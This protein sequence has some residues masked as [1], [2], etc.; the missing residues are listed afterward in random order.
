[1]FGGEGK[2]FFR[3]EPSRK[4]AGPDRLRN[5]FGQEQDERSWK[6]AGRANTLAE[7]FA[8]GFMK[9]DGGPS[10]ARTPNLVIKS[11][12]LYR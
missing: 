11:H 8:V 2:R 7:W 6:K 12:L 10:G 9:K 3:R 5:F 4:Y 1:M